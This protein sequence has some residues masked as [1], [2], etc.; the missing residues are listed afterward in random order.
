MPKI[1][2]TIITFFIASA[3][4]SGFWY[5][6]RNNEIN[7]KD[8]NLIMISLSNVS[9]EHMSLYGYER[10]TTPNLD[11][12]AEGT[13]IFENAFTHASWTLPVATSLFT[14]L[15]PYAHQVNG[16]FSNNVL[17]EDIKTFPEILRDQGYKTAAFTGGL[18]YSNK[19]GHMR[20]F[21]DFGEAMEFTFAVSYASFD[22]V[23]ERASKWLDNNSNEKFF[24]FIHGYDA[25]CPFD[26]PERFRGIF[27]DTE[28]KNVSVNNKLCLRG[29]KNSDDDDYEAYYFKA[30]TQKVTLTQD[31]VDYLE[32]LYDEQILSVDELV[33]NFLEDLDR[34]ILDKTMIVIFSD[35]GEMFAKHGRF[36][37]AGSV[38]GTLYDE[39]IRV[40]LIMK[41]PK[42]DG[43][44]IGGLVQTIDMMPA[45]LDI[46]N[47][48]KPEQIQGKS[49]IPL[50]ERKKEK[51]NEYVFGGSKFGAREE[52][53][54]LPIYHV[55][56]INE[57]VRSSDWKLIH[58][59]Q[60]GSEGN[61]E[62]EIY[63]LYDLENDS[64]EL[65]N[66]ADI[67]ISVAARLK[68]V[69]RDW[70]EEVA[71]PD[72]QNGSSRQLLSPEIIEAA[73][74]AGYW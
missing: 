71:G 59:V 53:L 42:Q 29:F 58:E 62:E 39:V 38:R 33:N 52:S 16:R 31:D 70:A 36:G 18:D 55:Q 11:R 41:I 25:H 34:E 50:M 27:S 2:K 10:L 30:G 3:V 4:F 73:K 69:L 15:Y 12:W 74:E 45:L 60:F 67:E 8:C 26:P 56:S 13:F 57:F 6:Q 24:L 72:I 28:G 44:R 17:N 35:H 9:A 40:P 47:L 14:S 19:F 54:A 7:C 63:E 46:L 64:A 32:D 20:G 5:F 65:N 37:R 66:L 48:P 51:I 68:E 61:I 23:M 22:F 43:E 1:K 49:L 21:D